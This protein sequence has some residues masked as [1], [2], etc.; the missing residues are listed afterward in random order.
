MKT[1]FKVLIIGLVILMA[2]PIYAQD[3][4]TRKEKRKIRKE[5]R[6]QEKAKLNKERKEAIYELAED[7]SFVVEL[8]NV[9][10]NNRVMHQVLR[11]INFIKFEGDRFILQT[12]NPAGIGYN[13]LGGITIEG[14]VLKYEVEKRKDNK[15]VS[16]RAEIMSPITGHSV[17]NVDLHTDG[18]GYARFRDNW[19]NRLAMMGDL[20]S[21]DSS[22]TY[23]GMVLW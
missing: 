1:R 12:G 13:G 2:N 11:E 9:S 15:P 18:S 17:I 5:L 8:Y 22:G 20:A 7:G 16:I 21:V 4:L 19:G 3:D 6:K 14:D 10:Q 23:E